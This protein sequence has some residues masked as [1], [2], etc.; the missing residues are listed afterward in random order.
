MVPDDGPAGQLGQGAFSTARCRGLGGHPERWEGE[1]EQRAQTIQ[2]GGA[3]SG[4][5][6]LVPQIDVFLSLVS[7]RPLVT[8]A[9]L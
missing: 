7:G 5:S 4:V 6:G 8:A 1:G 9:A 2:A 3:L